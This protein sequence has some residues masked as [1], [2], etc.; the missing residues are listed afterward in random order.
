MINNEFKFEEN[1]IHS[2]HKC[3]STSIIKL[4]KCN[5]IY[6]YEIK[7]FNAK[8]NNTYKSNTSEAYKI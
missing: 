5:N 4:G 8:E 6:R 1:E 7:L 3:N 2:C